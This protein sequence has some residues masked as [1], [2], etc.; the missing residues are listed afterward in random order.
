MTLYDKARSCE[1]RKNLN[2]EPILVRIERSELLCFGRVSR[3][4]QERKGSPAGNTPG[5][6]AHRWS[7]YISDLAWSRLG[8]EPAELSEIAVDCEVFRVLGCAAP[9]TLPRGNESME[10]NDYVQKTAIGQ[11]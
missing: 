7:I 8:V 3:I 4:P 1:I 6:A 2:V 9:A 5:K 11:I 10:I